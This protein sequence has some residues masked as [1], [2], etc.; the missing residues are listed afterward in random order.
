MAAA[1]W[2]ERGGAEV[3]I[4]ERAR[5]FEPLGHFITLKSHGVRSLANMGLLESCRAHAL[6]LHE[7]V[8]HRADGRVLRRLDAGMLER[9]VAGLLLFRRAN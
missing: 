1:W 6:E 4:I 5:A 8:A 9:S 7:V 3:T 2:L